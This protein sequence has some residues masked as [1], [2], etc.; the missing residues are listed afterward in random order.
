LQ[1]IPRQFPKSRYIVEVQHLYRPEKLQLITGV[2]SLDV[3]RKTVNRF[4][5]P[6]QEEKIDVDNTNLYLYSQINYFKDIT[7]TVGVSADFF[8]T[9]SVHDTQ[10][11]PKVG[12]TWNFLPRATLRAAILR[13]FVRRLVFNQT[14]EPTQ[15]AGFN[16]FFDDVTGTDAWRYGVGIDQMFSS[17]LYA[18]VEFSKRDLEVPVEA[19]LDQN[20]TRIEVDE[21]EDLGRAYFYWTP[22]PKLAFSAEYQYE[23]FD[24]NPLF[25]PD[26]ISEI[27]THRVPITINFFDHSGFTFGLKATYVDQNADFID[28]TGASV[29]GHDQFWLLDASIKYRLPKR[30]GL[31]TVEGRNLELSGPGLSISGY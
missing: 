18:G 22:Y 28:F 4:L 25:N 20:L 30:W 6:P 12:L 13:N 7:L 3:N 1:P 23:R 2:G 16:Q 21:E 14:I 11:N 19:E 26:S 5:F 27:K 29:Q 8:D 17:T 10:I 15:V 31:I 24:R 9:G